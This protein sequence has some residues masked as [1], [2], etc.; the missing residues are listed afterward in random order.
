MMSGLTSAGKDTWLATNRPW[1]PVVSLDA[2]PC[3]RETE[4]T[5][6]QGEVIQLSRERCLELPRVGRS[7]AF[8]GTNLLRMTRQ[9]WIDLFADHA[10]RTELGMSNPRTSFSPRTPGGNDRIL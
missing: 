4:A 5:D 10:S 7:F 3:E 8:N 1:L 6:D 2:V 9:R